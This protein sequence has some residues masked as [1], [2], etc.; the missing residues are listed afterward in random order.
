MRKPGERHCADCIQHEVDPNPK[1]LKRQQFWAAAGHSFKSELVFY[2]VPSNNNGKMTQLVYLN[3]ILRP[4]V[5]PWLQK[6][7]NFVLEEDGD[8]GHGPSKN[9]IV[10]TWKEGI[11]LKYYFN[12][13]SSPDLAPIENCWQAPKQY[14]A[15]RPHWD[16]ETTKELLVKGWHGLQQKT[17]DKWVDLMPQRLKDVIE[18]DVQHWILAV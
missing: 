5:L 7:N 17:I 16:E 10:R 13:P 14:L 11:G 3:K 8:S 1:D 4:V 6:A 18:L 9:N 2:D 12:C 15:A